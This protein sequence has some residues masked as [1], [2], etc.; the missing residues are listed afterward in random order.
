LT[1]VLTLARITFRV[2]EKTR[3]GIKREDKRIRADA[4]IEN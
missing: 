2:G 3:V 4:W 1:N